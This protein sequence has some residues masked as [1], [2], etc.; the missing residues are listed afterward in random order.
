MKASLPVCKRRIWF[1][2]VAAGLYCSLW[3]FTHLF[4]AHQVRSCAIQAMNVPK[5]TP[6]VSC[7]TRAYAPFLIRADYGWQS[8]PVYGDGGSALYLWFFGRSFRI[9]ELDHWAS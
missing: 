2:V 7:S 1:G 4:G 8:G 3:F 5:G 6:V 9:W